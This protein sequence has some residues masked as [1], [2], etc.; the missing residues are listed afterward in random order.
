MSNQEYIEVIDL[1]Q[2][3]PEEAANGDLSK[4]TTFQKKSEEVHPIT[5]A[6]TPTYRQL[7][8]IPPV[9]LLPGVTPRRISQAPREIEEEKPSEEGKPSGN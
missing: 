8:V 2:V 9:N 6:P 3:N 4:V 7:G 1:D 5:V